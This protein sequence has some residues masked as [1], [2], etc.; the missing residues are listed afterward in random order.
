MGGRAA[1]TN[2][3]YILATVNSFTLSNTSTASVSRSKDS[4]NVSNVRH[5]KD[6]GRCPLRV[7]GNWETRLISGYATY[8]K[9]CEMVCVR[10]S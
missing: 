9:N 6:M 8:V 10:D 1:G 7:W 2:R 4:E 3:E 5:R